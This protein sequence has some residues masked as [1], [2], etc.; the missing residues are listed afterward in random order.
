MATKKWNATQEELAEKFGVSVKTIRN[1]RLY[2]EM[3][4]ITIASVI[5]FNM[6]DVDQWAEGR[7]KLKAKAWQMKNVKEVYKD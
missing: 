6:E 2:A 1:W 3:P 5:R 7:S 4:Y